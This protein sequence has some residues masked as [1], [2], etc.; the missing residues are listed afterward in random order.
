MNG[1]HTA[2]MLNQSGKVS[3]TPGA[4]LMMVRDGRL[5]TPPVT[6]DILESVT[7]GTLMQ[8]ASEDLKIPVIERDVDRTELYLADELIVCGT[9]AEVVPM[10]SVDRLPV[11]DGAAGPITRS[12][13][14]RYFTIVRGGD[15]RYASSLTPVYGAPR[16]GS[17]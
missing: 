8:I 5:I 17:L 16:P 9:I 11:G 3:E 15:E 4:C 14:E 12:L 7:R 10:I 13:R 2:V 6:A 1:Y